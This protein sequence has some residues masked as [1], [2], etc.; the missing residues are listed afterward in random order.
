MKIQ[1]LCELSGSDITILA[2]LE[3]EMEKETGTYK[4]VFC[5]NSLNAFPAMKWLFIG[6]EGEEPMAFVAVFAPLPTEVEVIAYVRP[7][8]RR[9]GYFKQ[10]LAGVET[11]AAS[12]GIHTVL[13]VL[14]P[15][16]QIGCRIADAKKLALHHSEYK[17][18]RKRGEIVPVTNLP[19][20]EGEFCVRLYQKEDHEVL[21][22]INTELF[23]G[24]G[25]FFFELLQDGMVDETYL[26][27]VALLND[28]VIGLC[29]IEKHTGL[30]FGFGI[31]TPWQNRGYGRKFLDGV[32]ARLDQR[33]DLQQLILE[34][35]SEN[36]AAFHLYQT[37]G[38]K[39]ELQVDYRV[40]KE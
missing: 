28:S 19:Y 27:F 15:Q 38:F 4:K 3:K 39:T 9:C 24:D 5:S 20:S 1:E 34:V 21:K 40:W 35:D 2:R 14:S 16:C 12:F 25:G 6:R 17:M 30:L 31:D 26:T 36:P 22:R 10:L 33:D 29:H 18:S 13:C 11:E 8:Y 32:L 37:S 23:Q 7:E